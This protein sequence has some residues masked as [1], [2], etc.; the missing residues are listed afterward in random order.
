M[1]MFDISEVA[2]RTGLTT[3]AL[4]FYEARGLVKPL[5]TAAGRRLF[6][7]G[8]LARLHAI[9]ALKRAGFTLTEIARLLADRKVDLS[10]LVAAQIAALEVQATRI[11]ETMGMLHIIQTRIDRGEPIDVATLCS[12]IRQGE[13]TMEQ[14]NWRQVSERYLT[15]EART[16][17]AA[18]Y[19]HLPADF[20]QQAYSAQ[21]AALT[22]RIEAA[23]PMD[24]ASAEA[25]HFFEE[26]QALLAPFTAIATPAMGA[27]VTRMYDDIDAWKG[28]QTPPFSS[29][30]WDFIRQVGAARSSA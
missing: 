22:R 29:A 12:L 13:K 30:V 10:R 20:D 5:R 4:R 11:A 28:E 19:A 17:F 25:Q 21:W 9:G 24:P 23:L 27:A 26:W 18:S 16:D 6:G 7:E 8:E 14:E 3:P 1:D 15:D 2:R